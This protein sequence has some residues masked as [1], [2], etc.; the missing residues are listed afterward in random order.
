MI[1]NK[2]KS[3]L[4]IVFLFLSNSIFS[5]TLSPKALS[6][7]LGANLQTVT[8]IY[9]NMREITLSPDTA[10]VRVFVSWVGAERGYINF[11]AVFYFYRNKLY[12]VRFDPN[13]VGSGGGT[14]F[15]YQIVSKYGKFDN[16]EKEIIDQGIKCTFTFY[17]NRN[18]LVTVIMDVTVN[19][20]EFNNDS[21]GEYEFII[22]DSFFIVYSDPSIDSTE[23][24][25]FNGIDFN[26]FYLEL[27]RNI[28]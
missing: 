21:I 22:N 7:P 16:M 18:L 19:F 12:K 23:E 28:E 15:L 27:M 5:Q 4:V 20:Y 3:V 11:G 24:S 17:Q 25:N 26:E 1:K 6:V 8:Q 9:G 10:D 14:N 2:W 13:T